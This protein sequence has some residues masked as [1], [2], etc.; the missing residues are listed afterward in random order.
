M[1]VA[2]GVEAPA[3][4]NPQAILR[5]RLKS[6]TKLRYEFASINGTNLLFPVATAI[7]LSFGG[8][9]WLFGEICSID[10]ALIF[11]TV[12]FGEDLIS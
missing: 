10:L 3:G 12:S 5:P 7:I 1:G 9:Y 8:D 4:G 6:L 2:C 11:D